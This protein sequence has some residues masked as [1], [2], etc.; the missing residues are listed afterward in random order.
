M[1]TLGILADTHIP[2]RARILHRC[3]LPAFEQANVHAI[4]HAG[5][6]CSP[7][8]LQSLAEIAPVH[9]V[10]GNRDIWS[11]KQLPSSLLLEF[12]GFKIGLVHG[13]GDLGSYIIEKARY[14]VEGLRKESYIERAARTFPT[15]DVVVFGHI[16]VPVLQHIAG[17]LVF[18]PGSACCPH[19]A[20]MSPSIGLLHIQRGA[21]IQA[22]IIPMH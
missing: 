5:D 14:M 9:A 19:N 2:D 7:R 16:H 11:L 15:A 3:L 10:R 13:H 18:N 12:E 20:Q 22:E 17:R 6:I 8:V 4:L 1:I 21:A